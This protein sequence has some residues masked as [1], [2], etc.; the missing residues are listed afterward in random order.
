M[1]NKAKHA[2]GNSKDIATALVAGMINARDI[3]FLDENTENPK[4][5]WIDKKGNPVIVNYE[6][7]FRVDA[8]PEVGEDGKIYIF[9]NESY[10]WDGNG[11]V[12]L[13]KSVDLTELEAQIAEKASVEEVTAKIEESV[14]SANSYT[15]KMIEA[16]SNERMSQKFEITDVPEG[17]LVDYKEREIR[18]LCPANAVFSEQSVGVGGDP[19]SYYM[20]FKT[21]VPSDDVTGYIEHIGDQSDETVLTDFSFDENGRKYQPTWLA[22]AKYDAVS[23]AWTYY[24]ANSSV[25]KFIGW[26]YQ[27]DWYNAN[28]IVIATDCVRINL[29]NENC[30]NS[31]EPYYV[32]EIKKEIDEK[33]AEVSGNEI[34][35]F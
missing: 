19:Q 32:A 35:E 14:A 3:L 22:L 13:S 20:T 8:L 11:F 6:K 28:G 30:H 21:Y 29:S 16:V 34:I 7:I 25:E 10:F 31:F 27:I 2:F 15:D 24:G 23:D 33:I 9:N 18:V 1:A 26:D 17:T 4:L 12:N 5:G